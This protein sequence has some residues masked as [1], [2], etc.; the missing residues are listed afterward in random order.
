MMKQKLLL[1]ATT[2]LTTVTLFGCSTSLDNPVKKESSLVET[3]SPE[4]DTTKEVGEVTE[5]PRETV[6]VKKTEPATE[7][8]K[9]ATKTQGT[10]ELVPVEFI[11]IVDGDTIKV[12]YQGEEKSVR[13]LL[14]DTPETSHPRLGKQPYGEE[15]K[16]FNA[17][18]VENG[19]VSL[20]FDVGGRM[21]RYGRLLA[22]IYVDGELVQEK[23]VREGLA[24]VGYVYPP[25]TRHLDRLEK[26]QE[27][28]KKEKKNIWSDNGFVN[29]LGEGF[30]TDGK[31]AGKSSVQ[32]K[33]S[34]VKPGQ[35]S[36]FANCTEL[37]EVY[38]NGVPKGHQAYEEKMDRDKDGY[39]CEK[40]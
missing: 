3:A 21:D 28:A 8:P 12:K 19:Q 23:L 29:E 25:S 1:L 30:N 18:L 2:L 34:T 24:R 14:I 37:R 32:E 22:Y 38:P 26:A 20:E 11:R 31:E 16:A 4:E 33:T 36:G 13:Y 10:T 35:K 17:S 5:S 7:S 40:S 9:K 6:E 39:A 27:L 15:A